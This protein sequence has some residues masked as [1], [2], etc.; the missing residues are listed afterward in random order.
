M[1]ME[2]AEQHGA[3]LVLAN[4][5]DA[6]RLA[7]AE[8]TASG[9]R[10]FRG[11]E[12]GVLLAHWQ[13]RQLQAAGGAPDGARVTM[14]AS[15]V[16]SS[17]LGAL[18]K[19]EGFE[20]EETLTGFKWMGQRAAE[21]REA[22]VVVPFAYE[23][24]IGYCVGDMLKDKDGLSAAAV[25]YE[26]AAALR[27]EGVGVAEHYESLCERYGHFVS[28]NG[29]IG[30]PDPSVSA[31]IFASLRIDGVDSLVP[32]TLGGSTVTA[33]R[34]LWTGFDS[35][36]AD[37]KARLPQENMVTYTLANGGVAT[38]RASGTEPKIK[39]YCEVGGA[40]GVARAEV[41]AEV[42]TMAEAVIEELLKPDKFGLR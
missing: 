10:A 19:A 35:A 41:A 2:T 4:D 8:K 3:E 27:R 14:L 25:F 11:D 40:P 17:M 39:Y 21:L 37:L 7:V 29:S 16:S 42:A 9:W 38:L 1:A 18:A 30:C 24:A 36:H 12:I 31:E 33:V 28:Q 34:D 32:A 23:E 6:D 22:G 15:T 26:M 5:P 13:W 20:F